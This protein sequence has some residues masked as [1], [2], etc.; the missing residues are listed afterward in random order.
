MA[1]AKIKSGVRQLV[2]RECRRNPHSGVRELAKQLAARHNIILSKS[3][4]HNI[5]SAKGL[6]GGK[7]RK[8]DALLYKQK[9]IDG[10]DFVMLRALDSSLGIFDCLGRELSDQ[11]PG[12]TPELIARLSA[13][14]GFCA[15]SRKDLLERLRS[16]TGPG[17][18]GLSG[19]SPAKAEYF[20]KRLSELKP[21]VN[22]LGAAD[23]L[24]VVTSAKFYFSGGQVIFC[25]AAFSTFWTRP[26]PV[27]GFYLPLKAA[28]QRVEQMLDKKMIMVQYT[29]SFDC[30][31]PL[32]FSFIRGLGEGVAK[33]ELLGLKQEVLAKYEPVN[34][35]P[36]FLIGYCPRLISRALVP[37]G[38][39]TRAKKLSLESGDYF[40][41]SLYARY[42]QLPDKKGLVLDNVLLSRRRG[43]LAGWAILTDRREKIGVFLERYLGTWPE[44][45]SGFAKELETLGDFFTRPV[46]R[47]QGETV[48]MEPQV[49]QSEKDFI[50][51][52]EILMAQFKCRFGEFRFSGQKGVL[53]SGKYSF[54]LQIKKVL[55]ELKKSFNHS[56]FTLDGKR[57]YLG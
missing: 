47:H 18:A 35:K 3:A 17:I 38:K 45:D 19:L 57:I 33:V 30:L 15:F 12:L 39:P 25:D 50:R 52:V 44:L 31:S 28:R 34:L 11:F 8:Q 43:G 56:R 9:E 22:F 14:A 2:L 51:L 53:I 13:L 36:S 40:Y 26:C 1:R 5:I 55:P 32:V 6:S 16:R 54:R 7:G 48:K 41:S 20:L 29:K 10:A 42:F 27:P 21:E 46:G 23:N 24:K 37:L 49:F 4:I